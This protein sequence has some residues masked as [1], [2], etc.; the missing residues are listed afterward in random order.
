MAAPVALITG[1][2]RRLGADIARVL[3][4]RGMRVIIHY[5]SSRTDAE[6]LA[7]ELN[8]KRT[9]SACVLQA[10]LDK[11]DQV[12]ILANMAL[13][14]WR[15]LDLLVNNASAFYATPLGHSSDEDWV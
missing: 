3:H 6:R 12:R 1:A 8:S 7:A 10:D 9:E 15:R 4:E 2:A 5:R 14:Q 13:Q 11:P